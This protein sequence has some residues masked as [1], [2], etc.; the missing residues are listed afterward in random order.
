MFRGLNHCA[1][2]TAAGEGCESLLLLLA[3]QAPALQAPGGLSDR[4]EAPGW[5]I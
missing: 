3:A 2:Q 4:D 1:W 5:A